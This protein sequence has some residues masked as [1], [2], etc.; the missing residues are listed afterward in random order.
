[1]PFSSAFCGKKMAVKLDSSSLLATDCFLLLQIIKSL[2]ITGYAL[3]A[4]RLS[5]LWKNTSKENRAALQHEAAKQLLLRRHTKKTKKQTGLHQDAL[6]SVLT[7]TPCHW[8]R[9]VLMQELLS[10]GTLLVED[11][12][13]ESVPR[14]MTII[15]MSDVYRIYGKMMRS[16]LDGALKYYRERIAALSPH[17]HKKHEIEDSGR[18]PF[19]FQIVRCEQVEKKNKT[20]KIFE[21]D[22]T[23]TT[24]TTNTIKRMFLTFIDTESTLQFF[25]TWY[26]AQMASPHKLKTTLLECGPHDGTW[27]KWVLDIDASDADLQKKGLPTDANELFPLVLKMASAVAHGLHA[28]GFL[29]RPCHFAITSRHSPQKKKCS[30]HVVLC[31]LT[32]FE[33]WRH[34]L[35]EMERFYSAYIIGGHCDADTKKKEE[36]WKMYQLVDAAILRNSRGQYIQVF[37]L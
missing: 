26:T 24:P 29:R 13:D 10:C 21:D 28:L 15:H 8:S 5:L 25:E 18:G 2:A 6:L 3:E 1:M 20:K 32:D 7:A 12:D 19:T 31:A 35:R 16:K 4:W 23:I 27:R 33:N 34:A 17:Y 22:D 9:A 14:T 37:F 36:E 30:W 11:K